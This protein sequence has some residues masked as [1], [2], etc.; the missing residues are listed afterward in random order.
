[1]KIYIPTVLRPNNQITLSQIPEEYRKDTY[2]LVQAWEKDQ[3]SHYDVNLHVLPDTPEFHYSYRL[4]LPNTR[5]YLY[6]LHK[7]EKIAM[8]DD[9]VQFMRRNKKYLIDDSGKKFESNMKNAAR[10]CNEEDMREL[11]SMID[12]HLDNHTLTGIE[13]YAFPPGGKTISINSPIFTAIFFNSKKLQEVIQHPTAKILDEIVVGED[14]TLNA[15]V[16]LLGHK[17]CKIKTFA[18]RNESVRIKETKSAI[19][20]RI[21]EEKYENTI[22]LWNQVFPDC[23]IYDPT[24][25]GYKNRP[26]LK[27]NFRRVKKL[28]KNSKSLL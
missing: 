25:L 28:Y 22:N 2:L 15:L 9:D 20:D 17:T 19:W 16:F 6:R 10:K 4:C 12:T 13:Y 1:M 11:L 3:Y 18:F 8:L 7:D 5:N 21:D 14:M 26:E 23:V 24:K 27:I